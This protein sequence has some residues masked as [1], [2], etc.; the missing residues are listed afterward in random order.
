MFERLKHTIVIENRPGGNGTVGSLAVSRSEPDGHTILLTTNALMTIN[1]IMES[2][3]YDP[4]KDFAP[5]TT[6]VEGILALAVHPL[7]PAKTV[8]E[9]IDFVKKSPKPIS[10]GT[11]GIGSPQQVAGLTLNQV[12]GISLVHVPYRGGGPALNDLLGGHIESVIATLVTVLPHH[13]SGSLRINGFREKQ[14]ASAAPD[15]PTIAETFPNFKATSWLAFY[16]PAA[17]P[18]AVIEKLNREL[19]F[20]LRSPDV[21]PKLEETGLPV[22]ADRPE[23]LARLTVRR[24]RALAGTSAINEREGAVTAMLQRPLQGLITARLREPRP[25]VAAD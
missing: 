1:P 17:T 15:I 8:G 16:A 20:A 21:M 12:A 4:V 25:A 10:Y 11:A 22:I 23:D 3:P 9:F 7:V 5:L 18:K 13:K 19:V 2:V 14:R 24:S 6:A